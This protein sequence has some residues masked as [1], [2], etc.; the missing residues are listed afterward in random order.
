MSVLWLECNGCTLTVNIPTDQKTD[1]EVE[2]NNG[3]P[4]TLEERETTSELEGNTAVQTPVS[5][6]ECC[7]LIDDSIL[8]VN[9]LKVRERTKKFADVGVDSRFRVDHGSVLNLITEDKTCVISNTF[10]YGSVPPPNDTVWKVMKE[11]EF[12]IK[13]IQRSE[14]EGERKKS[15]EIARDILHLTK[16]KENVIFIII[17]GHLIFKSLIEEH[18]D[19][20]VPVE[21]WS[22]KDTVTR[23]FSQLDKTHDLFKVYHLDSI[24]EKIG[25]TE[26]EERHRP[27]THHS[28]H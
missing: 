13:T 28:I 17:T 4:S 22:W 24:V 19:N 9:G 6:T 27:N 21:L 14:S 2:I 11:K 16:G 26:S 20:E 1:S 18:L 7:V 25:F 3:T 10:I 23:E 15:E 12:P 5:H 8:W